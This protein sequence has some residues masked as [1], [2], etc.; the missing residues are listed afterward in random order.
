MK[1][2]INTPKHVLSFFEWKNKINITLFP[3][4]QPVNLELE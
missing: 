1:K 2:N 4:T 3:W